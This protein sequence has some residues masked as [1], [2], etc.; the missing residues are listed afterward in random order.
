MFELD[1][2]LHKIL[3]TVMAKAMA[4]NVI[5]EVYEPKLEHV[6]VLILLNSTIKTKRTINQKKWNAGGNYQIYDCTASNGISCPFVSSLAM[7]SSWREQ[8][9]PLLQNK[10]GCKRRFETKV[11]STGNQY[12]LPTD[13]LEKGAKVVQPLSM[14]PLLTIVF[15]IIN[16]I[17]LLNA[18]RVSAAAIALSKKLETN[19][20]TVVKLETLQTVVSDNSIMAAALSS[21]STKV[22]KKGVP[23]QQ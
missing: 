15:R 1:K 9:E 7:M 23:T 21:M 18:H 19:K 22:V 2:I 14:R 20:S 17:C 11:V 10:Y 8:I 3:N 12:S 16:P 13:L 5:H 6:D 4:R